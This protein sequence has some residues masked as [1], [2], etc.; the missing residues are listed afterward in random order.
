MAFKIKR[1]TLFF[2]AGPKEYS[3]EQVAAA[4][5]V[6]QLGPGGAI[7]ALREGPNRELKRYFNVPIEIVDEETLVEPVNG[8]II[9]A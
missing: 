2:P 3:P 9:G 4:E 6:L 7:V 1:L 5:L 8:R